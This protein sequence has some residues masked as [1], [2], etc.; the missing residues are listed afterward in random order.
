MYDTQLELTIAQILFHNQE[1]IDTN[2]VDAD[3]F[4]TPESRDAIKRMISLR[5]NNNLLN[6]T[7]VGRTLAI[8]SDEERN[9][10]E[11]LVYALKSLNKE[12]RLQSLP[13]KISR[14]VV[15]TENYDD[16]LIKISQLV[17]TFED[18]SV[19]IDD[20]KIGNSLEEYK[21]KLFNRTT[22]DLLSTGIY[23]LDV[24]CG[25]GFKP[26]ELV[27]VAGEPG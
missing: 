1:L 5:K 7:T 9:Q 4:F 24:K 25:K 10:F 23:M 11:E 17:D 15:D 20:F 19:K 3:D 6:E 21:E 18:N 27:I 22:E 14:I 26:G 8:P 16:K 2:L 12:R 13:E